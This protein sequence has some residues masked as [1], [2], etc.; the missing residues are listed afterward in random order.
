MNAMLEQIRARLAE[1][2]AVDAEDGDYALNPGTRAHLIKPVLRDA[3]VLI[4]INLRVGKE[5]DVILTKRSASLRKHTGQ[6]AFPGGGIDATDTDA[7]A[8]ALREAE[9]EIG[10]DRSLPQLIGQLPDYVTGSGFRIKPVVAVL[11][12]DHRLVANPEE[13]EEMF[14]V[15]LGFLMDPRNHRRASREWQ[16]HERF[17]YEIQHDRHLIWGVTAGI[18]RAFYERAVA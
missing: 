10:L 7:A 11:E 3:A 12:G 9:E 16:G 6:I 1:P 2:F 14:A 8:A 5:A 4:A 15:P 13:V 18:I 17:Y